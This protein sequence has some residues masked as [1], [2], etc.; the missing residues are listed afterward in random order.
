MWIRC[1]I[2]CHSFVLSFKLL[3]GYSIIPFLEKAW[4]QDKQKEQRLIGLIGLPTQDLPQ[5]GGKYLYHAHTHTHIHQNI[6]MMELEAKSKRYIIFKSVQAWAASLY[7]SYDIS[8]AATFPRH[9]CHK[10]PRIIMD[11]MLR[12]LF[13]W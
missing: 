11:T 10:C 9:A 7:I 4:K 1:L 13:F 12:C 5:T 2:V 3:M 8:G 6:G